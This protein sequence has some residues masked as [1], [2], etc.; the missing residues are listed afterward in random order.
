MYAIK[1]PQNF[2]KTYAVKPIH[3]LFGFAK[4]AKT[5]Q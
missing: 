1:H 2:I 3:I 5:K 4:I